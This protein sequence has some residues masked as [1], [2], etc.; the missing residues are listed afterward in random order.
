[1]TQIKNVNPIGDVDVPLLRKIV[2]RDETI[3]V[4]DDQARALLPQDNWAAVDHQAQQIQQEIDDAP[5]PDAVP[6]PAPA[7]VPAPEPAPADTTEG[8]TA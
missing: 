2:A 6:L 3:E 1:M 4:T 8:V 7:P 5:E